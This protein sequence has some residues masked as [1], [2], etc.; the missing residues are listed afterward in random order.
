MKN[1]WKKIKSRV[2]YSGDF[3]HKVVVD[4]V[5]TP[6]GKQGT[7]FMMNCKNSVT[8]VAITKDNKVI[9]E[10]SWRYPLNREI[11]ELPAGG[12]EE[13]ESPLKAA[14]R[15]LFEETGAKSKK[16]FDLGWDW[17]ND[18]YSNT[19]RY[20]YLA[21]DIKMEEFVNPDE[22]E[23]IELELCSFDEVL[24]K[25]LNNNLHDSRTIVGILLAD[26]FLKNKFK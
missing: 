9:L 26:S 4:D 10:R 13:S 16:W 3:G 14:K 20:T 15:E 21:L 25:V 23:V 18:G 12:F 5:I 7:Y 6:S 24:R 1:P 17:I 22:N 8:I 19:K 11:L 2:V